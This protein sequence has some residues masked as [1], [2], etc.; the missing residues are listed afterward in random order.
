MRMT[1]KPVKELTDKLNFRLFNCRVYIKI[2]YVYIHRFTCSII[3]LR[4]AHEIKDRLDYNTSSKMTW[5]RQLR[6]D[7]N[8]A[9]LTFY[10]K[11]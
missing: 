5:L 7:G 11:V 10:R 3:N 4:T 9:L 1:K 2:E 6:P 8:Q